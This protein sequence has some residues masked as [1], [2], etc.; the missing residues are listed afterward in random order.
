MVWATDRALQKRQDMEG[1]QSGINYHITTAILRISERVR[2]DKKDEDETTKPKK[3]LIESTD[4]KKS[5]VPIPRLKV[6]ELPY[7]RSFLHGSTCTGR[8]L[9]HVA[10][11]PQF[12]NC[13][14]C[15]CEEEDMDHIWYHCPEWKAER[16]HF[17]EQYTMEAI[18]QLLKCT[19]HWIFPG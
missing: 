16:Q 3:P 1:V 14:W 13:A 2:S 9:A 8:R 5:D 18:M 17:L 6:K 12:K 7:L 11:K 4:P 15:G 19:I 10:N